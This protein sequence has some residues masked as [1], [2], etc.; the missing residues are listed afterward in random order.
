VAATEEIAQ[1]VVFMRIVCS[2]GLSPFG[3]SHEKHCIA[4]A[5]YRQSETD[6]AAASAAATARGL[7]GFL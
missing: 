4:R 2:S 7:A 6:L 1:V 5:N 3:V